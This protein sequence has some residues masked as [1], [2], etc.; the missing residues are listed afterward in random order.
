MLI[1][2]INNNC[3]RVKIGNQMLF[4]RENIFFTYFVVFTVY[5]FVLYTISK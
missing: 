1:P 4:V 5:E 3:K 2:K